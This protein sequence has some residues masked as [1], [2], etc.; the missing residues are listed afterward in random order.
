MCRQACEGL[1]ASHSA[2]SDY[3]Y[4]NFERVLP[5]ASMYY[6]YFLTDN[7]QEARRLEIELQETYRRTF[8]DRPPL[9]SI[10][11]ATD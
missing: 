5:R 11:G 1:K 7:E 3:C 6:D 2:G 9:D 10:S 8:L 4:W